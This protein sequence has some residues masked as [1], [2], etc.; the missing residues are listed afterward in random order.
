MDDLE[1][2][3]GHYAERAMAAT[4]RYHATQ[5][6]VALGGAELDVATV[7]ALREVDLTDFANLTVLEIGSGTGGNLL[8]MVRWGFRPEHLTGFELLADRHEQASS[9]VP[10]GVHLINA[11]ARALGD[12]AKF[13]IVFQSTVLSSILDDDIQRD[14]ASTMWN[15]VRP[16][17]IVLSMDFIFNNPANKHVRAVPRARLAELFPGEL[18]ARRVL[19][20]PPLARRVGWHPAIHMALRS[21]PLLRTHLLAT[22]RKP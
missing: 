12:D 14:V 15:A 22:V 2:L 16:G 18:R 8:R 3:K 21:V 7:R 19:L 10:S 1:R 20:A 6:D 13:D 9:V 4:D 17:G 5:A 11:D